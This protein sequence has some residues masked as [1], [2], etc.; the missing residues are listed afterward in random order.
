[1]VLDGGLGTIRSV[2]LAIQNNTPCVFLEGSGRVADVIAHVLEQR[3]DK[4]KNMNDIIKDE[5]KKF[6]NDESLQPDEIDELKD[7]IQ[8]VVA[9]SD[10]LTVFKAKENDQRELG[11]LHALTKALK[12]EKS[13]KAKDKLLKLAID[14]NRVDLAEENIFT[15]E[16]QWKSN[17]L[18]WAMTLALVGNKPKFVRLLLEN[19]VILKNFLKDDNTLCELYQRLPKCFF[20]EKLGRKKPADGCRLNSASISKRLQSWYKRVSVSPLKR[21]SPSKHFDCKDIS[22]PIVAKEVRC[23]LGKFTKPIYPSPPKDG[24]HTVNID[25][26]PK[27]KENV[28]EREEEAKR[29]AAWEKEARRDAGRDL[30]LWAVLQ[31]N[32]GLADIAWGQCRDCIS[33][34]LAASKILKK[35]SEKANNADKTQEMLELARHYENHAIGVFSECYNNNE[36]RAQ[37]L[38]VRVSRLWGETTCLRLALEADD[39]NFV[40]HSG[41]QALLTQIWW[42]KL[43]DEN[44]LWKVGICMVI[45]P[46]IYIGFLDFREMS[47]IDEGEK[48]EEEERISHSTEMSEIDNEGKKTEGEERISHSIVQSDESPY[49]KALE[50]LYCSPQVKFF[51]NIVSYFAFL[52]LFAY[53]LM[54]DFQSTPSVVEILLYIWLFTLVCEEI[55]QLFYD[56][57][58]FGFREKA[59]VYIKE[60]WNILDVLS[61]LGFCLGLAFRLTTKLFYPGKIILCIDFVVFCLRLMAVFTI[62]RTLGPKI[63]IVKKMMMDI[64]FFMFLLSIWVMAYGVA[65][66]GILI[67]NDNRLDWIVRGAIYEPYLVIFGSF[68]ENIDNAGFDINSCSMNGT[69]PLKPKCPVLNENQMPVFP[70]WITIIMLCVYLLFANILLLNLL[71]AVFN[72]TFEEVH[73]NTDRIWKFQRYQLIK[74]YYSRPAPPPPFII[75]S[76]FY[77][78][79]NWVW[80]MMKNKNPQLFTSYLYTSRSENNDFSKT[81]VHNFYIRDKMCSEVHCI[82]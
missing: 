38:L 39:K 24:E 3:N 74:E 65:K 66:Q 13:E 61:I 55:R 30:F 1:M 60:V 33:A 47:E 18:E 71:I 80:D 21:S 15:K 29:K 10:L 28:E 25:P 63:I 70:E 67:E 37:K 75:L 56:P 79:T 5:L 40:A 41:V 52:I 78:F 45:F 58:N 34:A 46:L 82:V 17:E 62:S 4:H 53:V 31:N 27:V 36:E 54:I 6:F 81:L 16:S 11:I 35:M 23:L 12:D 76:H 64:F 72:Y 59:K 50:A 32:K 19:G 49:W 77:L 42:G 48:T 26:E 69:D 44:C 51:G 9:K 2:Y 68:P 43:S 8:K 73:E 7:K 57:D 20:L 14:W 22:L